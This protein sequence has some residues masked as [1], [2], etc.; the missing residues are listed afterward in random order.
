MSIAGIGGNIA[1]RIRYP[2]AKLCRECEIKNELDA[3]SC[4]DDL[5]KFKLFTCAFEIQLLKQR[6]WI[7]ICDVG[8]GNE[9]MKPVFR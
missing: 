9:K 3:E 7:I 2:Q 6:R 8:S 4:F 1:K 5:A